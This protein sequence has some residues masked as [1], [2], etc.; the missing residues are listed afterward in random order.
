MTQENKTSLNP[1]DDL[2]EHV[3]T[4]VHKWKSEQ[5]PETIHKVI[6]SKLDKRRDEIALQLLGFTNRWDKWEMDSRSQSSPVER[7]IANVIQGSIEEWLQKVFPLEISPKTLNALKKEA[8]RAYEEQISRSI[9]EIARSRAESDVNTLLDTIL[10][11]NVLPNYLKA[12]E[13]VNNGE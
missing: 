7:Y 4:S 6:T 10:E 3:A 5:S 13:I 11:S 9:R 8:Q 1:L 12:L 2:F